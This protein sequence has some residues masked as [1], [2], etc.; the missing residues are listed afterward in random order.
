MNLDALIS[1]DYTDTALNKKSY[2]EKFFNLLAKNGFDFSDIDDATHL[3]KSLLPVMANDTE[4]FNKF[5]ICLSNF[6][7]DKEV[8][9][10]DAV[11]FLVSDYLDAPIALKCLDEMNFIAVKNELQKRFKIKSQE[12]EQ[13]FSLLDYLG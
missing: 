6:N 9:I 11:C 12:K 4:P 7:K 3:P 2:K 13:D 5:N 10:L 8:N 1:N